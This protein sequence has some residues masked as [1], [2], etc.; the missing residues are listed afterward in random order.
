MLPVTAV[1]AELVVQ[2]LQSNVTVAHLFRS[3]ESHW[4]ACSRC[5]DNR[6]LRRDHGSVRIQTARRSA[7]LRELKMRF[8]VD[9]ELHPPKGVI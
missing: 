8:S 9:D 4:T 3:S 7:E 5:S 1:T 6:G 2:G